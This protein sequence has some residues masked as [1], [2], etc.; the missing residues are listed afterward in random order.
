MI[1]R[2]KA[3]ESL[4]KRVFYEESGDLLI[5]ESVKERHRPRAI[6]LKDI[7]SLSKVVG[8]RF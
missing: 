1:I 8:I 6:R 3:G 4:F 5:C 2:L 7:E